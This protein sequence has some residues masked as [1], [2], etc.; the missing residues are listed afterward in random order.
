MPSSQTLHRA[1]EP[2]TLA[3]RTVLLGYDIHI[4]RADN[5]LDAQQQP[6]TLD[7]W[8]D[9]VRTDPEM[10][11]DG[12]AEAHTDDGMLAYENTCAPARRSAA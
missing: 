1:A 10:R 4:T 7:A 2:G 12:P 6:I 5:W 9:Y 8:L 11:V 3:G